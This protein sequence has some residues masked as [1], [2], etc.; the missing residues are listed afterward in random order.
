[1]KIS[2]H[3]LSNSTVNV[4]GILARNATWRLGYVCRRNESKRNGKSLSSV[5]PPPINETRI[6]LWTMLM[7]LQKV[8]E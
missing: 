5:R 8:S 1:M 4:N 6:P 3:S 7:K 2:T